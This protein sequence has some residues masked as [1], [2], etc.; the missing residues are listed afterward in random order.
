MLETSRIVIIPDSTEPVSAQ[1]V[2]AGIDGNAS[3]KIISLDVTPPMV[4]SMLF[5]PA[6][7]SLFYG[8]IFHS[9]FC[10]S[11]SYAYTPVVL[12]RPI[13]KVFPS[14]VSIVAYNNQPVTCRLA[15]VIF[16][17]SDSSNSLFCWPLKKT[18]S[19]FLTFV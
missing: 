1:T 12:S 3:G 7:I 4:R 9:N 5:L 11:P 18:Y 10:P 14:L 19:Q 15:K 8:R 16:L 17:I 2:T 13:T 6:W